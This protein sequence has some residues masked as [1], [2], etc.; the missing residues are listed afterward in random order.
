AS[1]DGRQDLSGVHR[2][3]GH[4]GQSGHPARS[5][6]F[7]LILHLHRLHDD[8]PLACFHFVA[9]GNQDP[10]HFT[11]HGGDNIL[12]AFPFA[13]ISLPFPA[14]RIGNVHVKAPP[15]NR[16][17]VPGNDCLVA[18]PAEKH[19]VDTWL[20]LPDIGSPLF[21]RLDTK[22][23]G[24]TV[25]LQIQPDFSSIEEHQNH[26]NSCSRPSERQRETAGADGASGF[27]DLA[28]AT[29]TSAATASRSGSAEAGTL[30]AR[31]PSMNPV[32][33]RPSR[34]KESAT[35]RRKNSRFARMPAT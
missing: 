10:D 7:H 32:S 23:A 14:T 22:A 24:F 11:R 18:P 15:A 5:Q 35:R 20:D 1:L 2:G 13:M 27:W 31:K 33:R 34:K 25:L 26:R 9:W 19:R 21:L 17:A 30:R 4:R 12:T 29:A 16:N 28:R 8:E 3:A 6:G